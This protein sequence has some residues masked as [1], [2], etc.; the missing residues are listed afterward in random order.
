MAVVADIEKAFLMVS[1]IE[2]DRDVLRFLWVDDVELEEPKVVVYRFTR[3][4]FG[5]TSSPFLSN[6]TILKH[7]SSYKNED[8][9]FVRMM[10]RSLYVDDLSL[11]LKDVEEAYKL[12]CKSRE[13]MSEGGFNLRKWLSNSRPLMEKF[14]AME[15]QGESGRGKQS[16]PRRR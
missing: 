8:P 2:N 11:S 10:L 15:L 16:C 7:V 6:A 3:V 12:Y 5:V 4:V 14:A 13:R 9:V 1:V